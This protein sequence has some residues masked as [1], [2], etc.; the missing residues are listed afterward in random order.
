MKTNKKRVL[1]IQ[2]NKSTFYFLVLVVL[3]LLGFWPTYF[4]KFLDGTADFSFYFHFHAA[5]AATWVALLVLQ[6]MLIKRKKVALH[7]KVG[8]ST[9]VLLPLF[10]LS[11]ILLKHQRIG[12]EV[13]P[14]LGASLWLQLKDLVIIGI[15]YGIAIWHK[16]NIQIHA[17][18][19]IATGIVFIE[20]SLGR[21]IINVFYPND[22][23]TGFIVTIVLIY[24]LL[25]ALIFLERKQKQGRWIF[26]LLTVLY[27]LFHW[28]YLFEISFPAWDAFASWFA[29]LPLT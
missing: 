1:P 2:W 10:F 4:A 16:K 24:A 28:L 11:V 8:K 26:P 18:A 23:I 13:S 3:V 20:P 7:R 27:I 5:M 21:L 9:Y 19:M 25:L 14:S 12:G 6:P 29:L 17:R 22:F 15:M